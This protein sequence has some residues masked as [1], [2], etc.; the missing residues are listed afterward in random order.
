[1]EDVDLGIIEIPPSVYL[2]LD[3]SHS[4]ISD[5]D[6]NSAGP[7]ADIYMVGFSSI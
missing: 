1:L 2:N 7:G 3:V 4:T 6:S 5:I